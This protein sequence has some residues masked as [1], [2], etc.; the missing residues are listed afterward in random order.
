MSDRQISVHRGSSGPK[1]AIIGAGAI[2][3][4]IGWRLAKAGVAVD[5][6]ERAEAGRGASWAAAGMLAA[7]LE[8]E[9]GEERLHALNRESVGRWPAFAEELEAAAGFDV[10]LRREGTLAIALTA[11]EAGQLRHQSEYQRGLGIALE[12]LSAAE[13]RRREPRLAP[14]VVAAA[15]SPRDLQVNNRRLVAALETAFRRA[16][17]HLHRQ[18]P[19]SQVILANGRATGVLV[20]RE[21]HHAD[22]VVLAAGAWSREIGGIPREILPPVRPI[23]GQ[24]L[25]LHMA[26][27]APLIR[28]VIWAPGVYIV[29]RRHGTLILGATVEERGFDTSLTAG[30]MLSLLHAAWRALPD[31]AE[32]AVT[33]TWTG[34]RPGSPDDAPILGPCAIEGLIL[35][36]GHHRNGILLMPITADE[37]CRCV[38]TG[39]VSAI[40]RPFGA[41]RFRARAPQHSRPNA[42]HPHPPPQQ[43]KGSAT[44]ANFSP[45]PREG[46]GLGGS[47]AEIPKETTP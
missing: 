17:G 5:I 26:P 31:I 14:S 22:T 4:G 6:F 43:G 10:E 30:A 33:E 21:V 35:A 27:D 9:P 7:D 40:I 28:H 25:A 24:M 32:L 23:K 12:W 16:G 39:E 29:P 3:L 15:F 36:T 41:E 47:G 1:V 45:A 11:D 18:T 42:P 46:G 8:A 37:T 19:I 2:G 13:L 20:G 44:A 38:L 34:F